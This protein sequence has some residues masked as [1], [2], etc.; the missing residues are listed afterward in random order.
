GV[1]LRFD[2]EPRDTRWGV[3]VSGVQHRAPA[4]LVLAPVWLIDPQ[5]GAVVHGGVTV[6]LAGIVADGN[7]HLVVRDDRGAVVHDATYGLDRPAPAQG[8]ASVDIRL[9]PGRY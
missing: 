4:A 8:E 5:Q 2:G 9:A 3:D 6:R 7:V 1:R